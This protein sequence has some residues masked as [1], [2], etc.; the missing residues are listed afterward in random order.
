M[1]STH[2][3]SAAHLHI[4]LLP[5]C[6]QVE[7]VEASWALIE[8][9]EA[10]FAAGRGGSTAGTRAQRGAPCTLV[11]RAVGTAP[12]AARAAA[13]TGAAHAYRSASE[14]VCAFRGSTEVM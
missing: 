12:R 11:Q 5:P 2:M 10:M 8:R 6:A 7:A 4:D 1:H 3:C 9:L 14:A 13:A